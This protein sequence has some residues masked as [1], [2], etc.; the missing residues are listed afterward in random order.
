M[1]EP[2]PHQLG[3]SI[4]LL[5]FFIF[6]SAFL[7]YLPSLSGDF[8]WDDP[9]YVRDN[10]FLH[11]E[12]VLWDVLTLRVLARAGVDDNVRPVY[13]ASILIDHKLWGDRPWGYHL[14]NIIL[15]G[16]NA[17]LVFLLAHSLGKPSPTGRGEGEG[18]K[19]V[20]GFAVLAALVFAVHPAATEAVCPITFREDLLATF[21]LLAGLLLA[22]PSPAG[23]RDREREGLIPRLAVPLC[24]LLSVMSKESGAIGPFVL[25]LWV[26][27]ETL[28]MRRIF[29]RVLPA[30]LAVGTF[31]LLRFTVPPAPEYILGKPEYLGGSFLKM[32]S[33]QPRIWAFQLRT[34]CLPRSVSADPILPAMEFLSLGLCLFVLVIVIGI[35]IGFCRR[36]SLALFGLGFSFLAIL[37][38]SNLVPLFVPIADRYLY[39]PLAGVC[40]SLAGITS[41]SREPLSK[42]WKTSLLIGFCF[43]MGSLYGLNLKR[44][45]IWHDNVSL[46][47]RTLEQNPRSFIAANNL[48][49]ALWGKER[50]EEALVPWQKA[51]Q[52]SNGRVADPWAG[53]ALALKA[54]GRDNEASEAY[55]A[56]IALDKRYQDP[57]RLVKLL[58]WEKAQ[59][60]ALG[61]VRALVK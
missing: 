33:I 27:R 51:I 60:Q 56:A 6:L 48:G 43:W 20:F 59:A 8:V 1:A 28:D 10:P 45:A 34:I 15:H 46:W 38:V 41:G 58:L 49:F 35:G 11:E 36:S 54:L 25:A 31:L 12:G 18:T 3:R 37:P 2:V 52:L 44:Q 26:L 42:F 5:S 50:F 22:I 40:L 16:L 14:T 24:L 7:L 55:S 9:T 23:G 29:A 13:L 19:P 30:A 61:S 57:D 17:V 21:F 39:M 4:F 53:K 32:L 47:T